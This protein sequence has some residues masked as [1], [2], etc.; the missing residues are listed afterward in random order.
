MQSLAEWCV[1]RVCL[2]A[3]V[4]GAA[5]CAASAV[6][7]LG[8][9]G[10]W[11]AEGRTDESALV[12]MA[13]SDAA[14][15]QAPL[16]ADE[17]VVSATKTPIPVT[18]VTSAVEVITEH[19]IQ[20]QKL[21]YLSDVLRQAQGLAVFSN[22]GPGTSVNVRMRGANDTQTLVLIDGAIVNSATLG[23]YNFANLTTDNIERIEILRGAQSMLYGSD[24]MGGVI[25]IVTKRG[26]GAPTV[27]AFVEYGSFATLR[28]GGNLSGKSGMVD[29]SLALSRWDTS[30]FSAVNYRRGATERD[31]FHNWQ[32]SGR[33]GVDLPKDG[34]F[35]FTMRWMNSDVNLDNISAT[36]P[37]D[38]F[39]SKTRSQ[40]FV[41][42]GRYHQ[43]LTTWWAQTLT[44]SR[45]QESS[46]FLPGISQ[47]SLLTGLFSTPFGTPNETRVLSNRVEWQHDFQVAKPLL[48]SAGYQF[49]EQQGENDTGLT[50]HVLSSHAGFVQGQLNL[51]E[52]VFATA[53]VRHDA[54]NV[55]GSATTYRVTGGY[56]APETDTKFRTSY[57]TGFR[58]PSMNELYFPNFGNPKLGAEK[59]RSM[60]VGVDQYLF[61]KALKL[62]AGYFWNRYDNLITTTFDPV[63][64]APFSTFGFCPLQIGNAA[65]KGWEAGLTYNYSSE[66]QG[67]RGVMVQVTYTNTMARDL[68][69]AKRLPRWPT[70]QLTAVVGYQPIQPLWLSLTWRYVGSRYN[71]TG[72]RQ[73]LDNF[74]VWSLAASYG[75]N[76]TMQV[77]VRAD[78]LFNA[79]YEEIAS[80]GIP[81][82]SIFGGLRVTFGG[83]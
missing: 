79:K 6:D 48:L 18:Q 43:P 37:Q 22:G 28:E 69:T 81:T 34:R 64:C 63:F 17:V 30:S 3:V 67:L 31:A 60:D 4:F 9:T 20:R 58:A 73:D 39:G 56:Y 8:G 72:E 36:N 55:F 68:D 19:D 74:T 35:D 77:Y 66:R 83:S 14:G 82:R 15:E 76:K 10:A 5:I 1:Q 44:L 11:A 61:W 46:L 12:A 54:Y 49:R 24:A 23:S 40:E 13:D 65:T 70:D 27:G 33:V 59:S 51:W 62:S 32:G 53:G 80:A 52:R 50:P 71:T 7:R 38:V 29:Y 47:R 45:G 57:A 16:L 21:R 41:F 25:N 75:I 42:S 26:Q 2:R 78:N